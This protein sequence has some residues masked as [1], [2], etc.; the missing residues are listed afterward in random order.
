MFDSHSCQGSF[1]YKPKEFVLFC[2]T[3]IIVGNSLVSAVALVA[4]SV[5][6]SLKIHEHFL[7]GTAPSHSP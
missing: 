7:M 4:G 1:C 6:V 3:S 5:G 2:S